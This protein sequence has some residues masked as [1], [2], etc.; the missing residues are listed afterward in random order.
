MTC[1]NRTVSSSLLP[2]VG[3][4][5]SMIEDHIVSSFLTAFLMMANGEL[6]EENRARKK[7]PGHLNPML[8]PFDFGP[9]GQDANAG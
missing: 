7:D 2:V 8:Y 9:Q 3:I 1:A 6:G 4:N 5:A